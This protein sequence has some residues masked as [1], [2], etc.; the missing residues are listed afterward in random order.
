[1][2]PVGVGTRWA[3]PIS[4]PLSSGRTRPMALAAPVE[5]GTMFCAQARLR[6][7]LPLRCGP[8]SGIWSPV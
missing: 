8:S 4:L 7:L 1:M 2:E 5:L 6:R 3:A